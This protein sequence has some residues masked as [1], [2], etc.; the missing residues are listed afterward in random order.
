MRLN[1]VAVRL[2]LLWDRMLAHDRRAIASPSAA[3][4]SRQDDIAPGGMLRPTRT[5]L[6]T[7]TDTR[8]AGQHLIF[9]TWPFVNQVAGAASGDLAR[10]EDAGNQHGFVRITREHAVA[11][12]H[13]STRNQHGPND[14]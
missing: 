9:F 7:R 2:T 10:N 1:V 5:S 4:L 8:F 6:T 11:K 13:H 12:A 3:T 14:T